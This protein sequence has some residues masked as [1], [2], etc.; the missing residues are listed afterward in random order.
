M[1]MPKPLEKTQTDSNLVK[2]N[3]LN[4]NLNS[5]HIL[6]GTAQYHYA[7]WEGH[8]S[9]KTFSKGRAFYNVGAG[10]YSVDDS[11][12]L[13]V[14]ELQPYTIT[15]DSE[16]KIEPCIIFFESEFAEEVNRSLTAQTVQLLDNPVKSPTA[17]IDFVNKLYSRSFIEK[18]LSE[19]RSSIQE[20][21]ND[22]IWLRE[23]LHE[24]MQG[25]LTAHHETLK[26]IEDIPAVRTSTR[27][28]LYKRIY[29][30]K[31]FISSS[32][33]QPLTLDEIARV[34]CL[35][36]NHLLRTFKQVFR[37]TLHQFL[38]DLRLKEAKRLLE[39]TDLS[40]IN[41]CQ[42]ISFESHSSFS[43]LFRRHFGVSPE[44]YRH[45]KKGDFR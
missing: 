5:T 40:I 22:Q 32:F 45:Q 14:N 36:P 1:N 17:K 9:L 12:F 26:E 11:S 21:K 43:L 13:I 35:S 6:C 42:S 7:N 41:I 24:I 4:S 38:T 33:N 31:D 2:V 10:N 20:Q 8:L 29:R 27:E 16:T 44:K 3:S 39:K 25:I 28:E 30:A 37:Q 34:A 15:I 19:L 23:K 18:P